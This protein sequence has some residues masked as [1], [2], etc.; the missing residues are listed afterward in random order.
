[1]S[2]LS[3]ELVQTPGGD[4]ATLSPNSIPPP[5]WTNGDDGGS[6]LGKDS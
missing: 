3:P 4:L 6:L 5:V 2:D 1:M